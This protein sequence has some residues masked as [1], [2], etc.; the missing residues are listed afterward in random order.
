MLTLCKRRLAGLYR[1]ELSPQQLWLL[2]AHAPDYRENVQAAE[3]ASA[4]GTG[5]ESESEN[6]YLARRYSMKAINSTEPRFCGPGMATAA[7]VTRFSRGLP[8][9]LQQLPGTKIV[10]LVRN[11]VDVVV[12]RVQAKWVRGGPAWPSCTLRTI[13]RCA[14][15]LCDSMMR[16]LR[17]LPK[18]AERVRL[19]R[20]ETFAKRK[21]RVAADLLSWLGTTAN[22]SAVAELMVEVDGELKQFK[23][24]SDKF[25]ISPR[26]TYLVEQ[27]CAG[28]MKALGYTR[29][30]VSLGAGGKGD[31]Q[32]QQ[33]QQPQQSTRRFV[34][35]G[36]RRHA[37]QIARKRERERAAEGSA[38][39]AASGSAGSAASLPLSE[40]TI[41][42]RHTRDPIFAWC[43]VRLGGSEPL[44]RFFVRRDT[45]EA[46]N[47]PLC[48]PDSPTD[49][50]P[51]RHGSKWHRNKWGNYPMEVYPVGGSPTLNAA[52]SV[53]GS[54]TLDANTPDGDAAPVAHGRR[55]G[56]RGKKRAARLA[57]AAAAAESNFTTSVRRGS[58][59]SADVAAAMA[60]SAG[61]SGA[62]PISAA[63]A[64]NTSNGSRPF[65]FA[66]VRNP[67][68]RLVSAYERH[69]AAQ[70]KGTSIHRA[71]IRELHRLGDREIITFSHFV[72]WV[73]QQDGS[74]MHA[75]WKPFTTS[76]GFGLTDRGGPK[77]DFVGRIETLQRDV[78][79][80]MSVLGLTSAED[81][82]L[83]EQVSGKSA[84]ALAIESA[85]RA[86]RL[87]HYYQSDDT[88]DLIGL[89]KHKYAK[90]LSAFGYAYPGNGSAAPAWQRI[91]V[92]S[93]SRAGGR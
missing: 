18:G 81:R 60:A 9:T 42:L 20:W 10:Q 51:S 33:P 25:P 8:P 22:H 11:P 43:P 67:F 30:V 12:A 1:C 21:Q 90:D 93:R 53:D 41:L 65:T 7:L 73:A 50:C 38:A 48:F 80:V 92:A 49:R 26:S 76:C 84:P 46:I 39:A 71:W 4:D 54:S 14:S 45:P 78:S 74:V 28:V 85:D 77:Y 82:R 87:H 62:T 2:H 72:R 27:Q 83:W 68:D 89:V 29:T 75:A 40:P 66:F 24:L 59:T 3:E 70:D 63:G 44:L 61:G 47:A 52:A 57:A 88:H 23:A 34:E 17:T 31:E 19:L 36:S 56:R 69:I 55:L 58:G 35:R 91:E 15:E 32:P 6:S 86:L 64:M 5:E 37:L 13:E 79:H 16:T